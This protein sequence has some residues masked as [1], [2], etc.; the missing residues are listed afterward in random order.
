MQ[1]S[2]GGCLCS[3]IR[4]RIRGAPLSTII[5]HC[6]TCRRANA[7]PTVAWLTVDRT[8]FEMLSG[9][10]S[11]YRSSP[12][13]IRRFCGIC[14]SQIT[15]ESATSPGTIDVTTASLDKPSIFPPS[16]EVWLEHKVPW[17]PINETLD[18][19]LHGSAAAD[20]GQP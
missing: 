16:S 9:H 3:A 10:P 17:Q 11:S 18:Q 6:A 20:A 15:Y 14:G 1:I 7:A 13:V 8:Q 2:E 4:Y 12:G 5:C 19:F